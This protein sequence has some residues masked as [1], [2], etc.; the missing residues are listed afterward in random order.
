MKL[1]LTNDDGIDAPGIAALYIAAEGLGERTVV[2]PAFAQSG[3]SHQVTTHKAI[4][5]AR[6]AEDRFAVHGTPADCVR[7]ALHRLL[8]DV[9]WVLSGINEG[10]NLGADI[11][12]SGTVA[13]I[14]EAVLHGRPGIAV[15][16]YK[17]KELEIRWDEA[18]GWAAPILAD[19]I[20]RPLPTGG[21]WNVN[22]PHLDPGSPR[23]DVVFCDPD[24]A[25]LPLSFWEEN[26]AFYYDGVYHQRRR[27]L[28][29]DVDV[30]FGGSIAVSQL[31]LF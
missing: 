18:A 14:R 10:G 22:L 15:S 24:P 3:A 9:D 17:R 6:L 23:P 7:V 28:G 12:I 19:L 29:T 30:C 1:L 5:L 31:R 2:A 13:A 26:D 16:H 21:F 4:R 8:P 27:G 20:S 11:H 25:P